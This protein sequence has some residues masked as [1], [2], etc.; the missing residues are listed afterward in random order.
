MLDNNIDFQLSADHTIKEIIADKKLINQVVV[1]L[2]NNAMDALKEIAEN[3][4]IKI[5]IENTRQNRIRICIS[6]NGPPIAPEVQDK[7]FVPFFTTKSEGSGIGLSICQEIMKLHNGSL[8]V[9]SGPDNF[10]TFI[11][12]I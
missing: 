2:M 4:L 1:N 12:E 8:M 10:T 9:V 3:R 11:I 5:H 6:N 7:V